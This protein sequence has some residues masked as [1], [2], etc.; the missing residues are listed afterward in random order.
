MQEPNLITS[1]KRLPLSFEQMATEHDGKDYLVERVNNKEDY[2]EMWN[3]FQMQ[4][5]LIDVDMKNKD[6]L[7]VGLH[8]SSSCP[9]EINDIRSNYEK[10]EILVDFTDIN[11]NCTSDASPRTFIIGI[12]KSKSKNVST[13]TLVHGDQS[14][15]IPI[16]NK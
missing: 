15:P 3:K 5:D 16:N 11:S 8:E 6:V 4:V 12:D 10:Q 1:G 7:F 9:Y 14:V 2:K 13:V